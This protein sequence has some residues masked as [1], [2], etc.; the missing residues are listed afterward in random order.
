MAI[1]KKEREKKITKHKT[2]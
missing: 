2:Q 1:R